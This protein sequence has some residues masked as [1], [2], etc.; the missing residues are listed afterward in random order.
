MTAEGMKASVVEKIRKFVPGGVEGEVAGESLLVEE[1]GLDSL[2]L[3][4]FLI[5]L[6]EDHQVEF[7][8]EEIG[9]I[10]TIGDVVRMLSE[11]LRAAA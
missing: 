11:Q 3:V 5:D 2:D 1:L 10:R 6:Q 8:L 4:S 7:N 9:H